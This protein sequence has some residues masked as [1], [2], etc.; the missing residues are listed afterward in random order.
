[1]TN[2]I[3]QSL[4][5]TV[6]ILHVLGQ[7]YVLPYLTA[8]VQQVYAE[9]TGEQTVVQPQLQ[10]VLVTAKPTPSAVKTAKPRATKS[11]VRKSPRAV[12]PVAVA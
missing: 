11:S 3:I 12:T 10:P 5:W 7:R 9:F 6:A 4:L 2:S 8:V 1:M